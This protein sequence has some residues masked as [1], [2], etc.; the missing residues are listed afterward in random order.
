M[1]GVGTV[2]ADDPLLTVRL[3]GLERRS[4]LKVVI[5]PF[6]RTPTKSKL[7]NEIEQNP[8]LVLTSEKA[9]R[10]ETEVLRE[11]GAAVRA[12]A[13]DYRGRFDPRE[14]L[15]S[16]GIMGV[17][18]VLLEGGAETARRFLESG[19]VD[20]IALFVGQ[21]VIGGGGIASP[22]TESGAPGFRVSDQRRFGGDRLIEYERID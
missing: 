19:V 10:R 21:I 14:I 4:P 8:V 15:R 2:V 9:T 12:V 17:K 16:L 5:D 7:F 18:S 6:A 11:A 13:S 3:A 1:V 22:L 20:R